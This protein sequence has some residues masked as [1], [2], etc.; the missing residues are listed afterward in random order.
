LQPLLQQFNVDLFQVLAESGLPPETFAHPDNLVPFRHGSRCLGYV[1]NEPV[2]PIWAVDRPPY[3][4]ESLGFVADL[5]KA[6]PH[7][8]SALVL[9][10]RYLKFSD[11]GGLLALHEDSRFA[12]ATCSTSRA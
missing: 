6:A 9:L 11:G 5:V 12:A 3:P 8:H 4:M 7:V 2:V 10:A 1:L